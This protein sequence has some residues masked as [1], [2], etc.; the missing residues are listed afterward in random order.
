MT[1]HISVRGNSGGSAALGRRVERRMD[2]LLQKYQGPE[3]SEETTD[4]MR[5]TLHQYG[6]AWEEISRL[7]LL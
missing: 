3:L 4:R 5:Q 6:V 2:Q 7:D 1:P